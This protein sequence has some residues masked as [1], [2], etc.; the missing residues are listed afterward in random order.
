MS[1]ELGMFFPQTIIFPEELM[2]TF[3]RTL[4]MKFEQC[5]YLHL[6]ILKIYDWAS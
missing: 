6:M 4:S 3:Y 1:N 5:E 2:L